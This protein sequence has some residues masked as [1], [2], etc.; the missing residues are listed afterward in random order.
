M[1]KKDDMVNVKSVIYGD[2]SGVVKEAKKRVA[3]VVRDEDGNE[4][5]IYNKY[6]QLREVEDLSKLNQTPA[7]GTEENSVPLVRLH[8]DRAKY[9]RQ[10]DKSK[11]IHLDVADYVADQLREM[12]FTEIYTLVVDLGIADAESLRSKYSTL[13]HGMQRMNLGNKI[14]HYMMDCGFETF[15]EAFRCMEEDV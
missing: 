12:A 5:S 11:K 4:F 2:F 3:T 8:P 10:K 6:I 9:T 1:F 7:K 15:N 13:N 14:R